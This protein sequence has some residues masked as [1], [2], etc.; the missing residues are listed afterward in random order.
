MRRQAAYACT[1]YQ[2][3]AP[4]NI[5]PRDL[6]LYLLFINLLVT[7]VGQ[8]MTITASIVVHNSPADQLR[9]VLGCLAADRVDLVYVVDNGDNDSLRQVAGEFGFCHYRHVEN[10]GFG[11]GHNLAIADALASGTDWHVVLNAD[12]AWSG[13][14][15]GR[16]ADYAA[17]QRDIALLGPKV[18]YPDGI[19]Q[20]SCRMVP[21]PFDLIARRFLP[22]FLTRRRMRRYLMQWADH[23]REFECSYLLGS[24]MMMSR[25][26]LTATGGFD[27]RFFM[28]PEDIDI[29]RR[30]TEAGR[31]LYW[32]GAEI[33]HEH[34]AESRHSLKMLRIHMVNMIRYFNKWGWI[35]DRRRR[36][37]NRRLLR[38]TP[39][40]QHPEPGRG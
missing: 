9:K 38:E 35:A 37:A 21:T 34:A 31:V 18:R 20:Y 27:E 36:E 4:Q 6:S 14:V 1:I 24:F 8:N 30:M 5:L 23:D 29:S 25:R 10:R 13:E 40:A 32:P 19:L 17:S 28:Y 7:F 39:R 2:E 33:I 22:G 3:A 15:I 16:M 26:G 11:A 12:T